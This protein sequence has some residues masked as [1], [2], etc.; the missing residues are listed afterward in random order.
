MLSATHPE[1]A[2]FGE[3][4]HAV[5]AASQPAPGLDARESRPLPSR[6]TPPRWRSAVP[7]ATLTFPE[8]VYATVLDLD[9]VTA[10]RRGGSAGAA[11]RTLLVWSTFVP[12]YVLA[13]A[14][15]FVATRYRLPLLVALSSE[16]QTSELQ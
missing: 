13:V 7:C 12:A 11:R 4:H 10:S 14:A 1:C 9:A 2:A 15:F 5:Q 8:R 16:E 6:P 3:R